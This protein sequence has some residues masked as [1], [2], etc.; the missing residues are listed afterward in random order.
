MSGRD[1]RHSSAAGSGNRH[2]RDERKNNDFRRDR[3]MNRDR[4]KSPQRDIKNERER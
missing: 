3:H 4:T 1:S 2:N